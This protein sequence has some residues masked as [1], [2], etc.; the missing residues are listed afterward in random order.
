MVRGAVQQYGYY[1]HEKVRM[2]PTVLARENALVGVPASV[3][4]V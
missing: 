3:G 2:S 4:D 1:W